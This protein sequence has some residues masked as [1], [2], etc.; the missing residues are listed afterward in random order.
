VVIGDAW[1]GSVK[2][3]EEMMENGLEGIFSLKTAHRGYPK[4]LMLESIPQRGD[5]HFRQTTVKLGW[6]GEG[7]ER[8]ILAAAHRDRKP[9]LLVGTVGMLE[10]GPSRVRHRYK[11]QGG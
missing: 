5:T 10:N 7:A 8:H 4:K 3:C 1:F 6:E 9:M 11:Y 2:T